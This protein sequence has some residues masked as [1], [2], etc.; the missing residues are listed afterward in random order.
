[1]DDTGG[2]SATKKA[3]MK[4]VGAVLSR[5]SFASAAYAVLLSGAEGADNGNH[6]R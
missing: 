1:M 3:A 4:A 2:F 6:S 5:P